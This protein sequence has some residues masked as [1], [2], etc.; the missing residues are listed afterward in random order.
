MRHNRACVNC[1]KLFQ[2]TA[3]SQKIACSK[4]CY[5]E[6]LRKLPKCKVPWCTYK[7]INLVRILGEEYEICSKHEEFRLAYGNQ[8]FLERFLVKE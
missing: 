4:N 2:T 5:D 7:G 8:K 1:G 6:Y 3:L